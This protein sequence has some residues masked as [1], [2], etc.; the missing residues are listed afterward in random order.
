VVLASSKLSSCAPAAEVDGG[1]G[2]AHLSRIVASPVGVTEAE[3]TGVVVAPALYGAVV[4]TGTSIIGSS[5]DL[6]GGA[7]GAEVDGRKI[8]AHLIRIV[9][10]PVGVAEPELTVTVKAPAPY[11]TIIKEGTGVILSCSDLCGGAAGA[12]VDGRKIIAH[13]IR[14]VASPVGVAEAELTEE[15]IAPALDR[16]II[17]EGAG[18]FSASHD[19]GGSA[20]AT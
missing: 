9:A 13:L 16:A 3:L 11:G 10:S 7:T 5:G 19:L 12:E 18:M 17:E 8:I 15:I 20:A 14:I 2:V 6:H 1:E 4:E